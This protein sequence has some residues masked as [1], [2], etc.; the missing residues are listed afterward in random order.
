MIPWYWW[1]AGVLALVVLT[2]LGLWP[3]VIGF[4][5]RVPKEAWIAF[6]CAAALVVVHLALV[7]DAVSKA[8]AAERARGAAALERQKAAFEKQI[9]DS[10]DLAQAELEALRTSYEKQRAEREAEIAA[11]DKKFRAE[12]KSLKEKIN[13]YLPTPQ[14]ARCTDLPR[15]FLLFGAHAATYANGGPEIPAAPGASPEL[16]DTPSGVPVPT[17]TET[18]GDQA[19]AFR[20][21]RQRV[22]DWEQ[23]G[24]DVTG[25]LEKFS[26][27]FQ[28]SPQQ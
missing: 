21:C 27:I 16:A 8:T 5:R 3:L 28:R 25:Y 9:K 11:R 1:I 7:G 13:A 22:L 14:L 12:M 17:Y 26:A 4:L 2:Y 20:A 24:R 15:G 19:G 18:V 23:Y 6:G 10:R